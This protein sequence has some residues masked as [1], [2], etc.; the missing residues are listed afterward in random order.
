MNKLDPMKVLLSVVDPEYPNEIRV[1][2]IAEDKDSLKATIKLAERNGL[3]YYFILRLKELNVDLSFLDKE[4]EHW[5]GE[6]Q[7]LSALKKTLVFLNRMQNHYGIHYIIIKACTKIPHTPRDVDTLVHIEDREKIYDVFEREGMKII[8]SNDVE[9]A[10]GKGGY[11][12]L[13]IYSRIYYLAMTF[14][15][16]DFLWTSRVKDRMYGIE[17]PSLND[18]ANFLLLLIHSIVGHRSMT[19]LDFLHMKILMSNIQDISACRGHAYEKGWGA[20]FDRGL[21]ELQT[22]SKNIYKD[23]KVVSFPYLFDRKFMLKCVASIEGLEMKKRE[24]IFFHISLGLDRLS[25]ELE[26]M[27]FYDYLLAFNTGRRI[28]NSLGYFV[29]NRR[30]DRHGIYE[31]NKDK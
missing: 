30:G 19:L 9:T 18:E 25:Y 26:K 24:K 4:Q 6:L 12:K 29:R 13:D 7:K 11:T 22:I 10:F 31:Q 17:Y 2:E 3:Y 23:R 16:E 28:F 15:D 1:E 8:Y 14:I 5:D 27:P 21:E 20:I